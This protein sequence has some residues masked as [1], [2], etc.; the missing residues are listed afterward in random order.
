VVEPK[1]DEYDFDIVP[2]NGPFG[3]EE[4]VVKSDD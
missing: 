3:G 2:V 4:F 1:V